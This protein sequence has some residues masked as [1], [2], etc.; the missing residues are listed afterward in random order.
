MIKDIIIYLRRDN[1]RFDTPVVLASSRLMAALA[2]AIPTQ[3]GLIAASSVEKA[4][5]QPFSDALIDYLN[6]TADVR[7]AVKSSA[8]F[9]TLLGGLVLLTGVAMSLIQNGWSIYAFVFVLVGV[10]LLASGWKSRD[11]G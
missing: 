6:D 4:P 5:S 8:K 7:E 10:V 1:G 3:I 9:T 11:R 2:A